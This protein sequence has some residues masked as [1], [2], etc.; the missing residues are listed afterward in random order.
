MNNE[1]VAYREIKGLHCT[2]KF[3]IIEY[4]ECK[5]DDYYSYK[6]LDGKRFLFV[7]EYED[8]HAYYHELGHLL[9]DVF[10]L[11]AV[12]ATS[13]LVPIL[14]LPPPWAWVGAFAMYII[15]KW[16]EKNWERRAD[17]FAYE[18]TR[19]KYKP[20]QLEM[21]KIILLYRWLFWSHPPEIIR[22]MDE[23][24]KKEVPLIKLFFKS[25]L[26]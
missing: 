8:Q 18:M 11:D 5:A 9:F 14:F 7:G 22:T 3:K 26:A 21:N 12:L 24:Y 16:V 6:T 4:Y 17:I 20:I 1:W 15:V 23:Y 19:Q 10:W 2:K 25:L 13:V